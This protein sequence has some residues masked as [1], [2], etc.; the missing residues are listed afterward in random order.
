MRR[1]PNPEIKEFQAFKKLDSP[2]KVQDFLNRMPQNFDASRRTCRSPLMVLKRNKAHC[3]EGAMLAAAIFWYHREKPLILDLRT[4]KRDD[5]HVVALFKRNGRWGAVS[6]TNHAVLRYRDP[7]YESPRELAMSFFNEY[8]LW[9]GTKSMRSYSKPFD[10]SRYA[11]EK[12]ITSEK[13]LDWLMKAITKSGYYSVVP[14]KTKLRKASNIE[15]KT[16][17][18]IEWSKQGKRIN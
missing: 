13:N 6:K 11:P 17:K 14:P 8:Y 15:L 3:V 4:T 18:L 12:W 10:I 5:D 16:L 2:D 7:V 9:D 1:F